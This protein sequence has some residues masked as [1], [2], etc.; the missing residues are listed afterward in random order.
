[1]KALA[2]F[3]NICDFRKMSKVFREA[4]E[5]TRDVLIFFI[6]ALKQVFFFSKIYLWTFLSLVLRF[7][8]LGLVLGFGV[9]PK[10]SLKLPT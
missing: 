5:I 7:C 8:C 10:A 9:Y 1:M 2:C 3:C 4:R 6:L